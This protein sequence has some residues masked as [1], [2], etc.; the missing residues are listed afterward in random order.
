MTEVRHVAVIDVGKT[1]AK[2]ALVDLRTRREVDVRETPNVVLDSAPYPHHD[3]EGLWAFLLESLREVAGAHGVD[4]VTATTHG[5]A[6]VLVDAAGVP[7]VPMLDYEHDGPDELAEAYD[8]LRPD[9]A[10]SGSPRLP[11]GFNLGAQLHWLLETRPRLRDHLA[12]IVTYPQYWVGRLTGAWHTEVT[13]LGCHTDLWLPREGRLSGLADRLGLAG[14]M[15]PVRK[16]GDLVG[17]LLPA[18]AQQ[19]GL[20]RST[21]VYCGI[22]DS[23]ASLYPHLLGRRGPFSVL[24]TG[25]WVITMAIGGTSRELDPTRD[26]LMN[27]NAYGDPVPS[28]R[29]MGGREFEMLTRGAVVVPSEADIAAVLSR[30][31]TLSP[32]VVSTCGPFQG[33]AAAWSEAEGALSDGERAVVASFYLAMMALTCQELTGAEGPI[34]TEGPFAR[35]TPFLDLLAAAS[36]RQVLAATSSATGTSIGAALLAASETRTAAD[37]ATHPSP[38]S[39]YRE[40][41]VRYARR[42]RELAGI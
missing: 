29:F 35:N 11:H 5:A 34:I 23:N 21:P 13:S 22:H 4:A 9:F 10:R 17:T 27:V 20:P 6:A 33:R 40:D 1:N 32:A 38:P 24:S 8:A 16:A 25:T 28:A 26:T 3:I 12:Y 19:T 2:L 36:G 39:A 37:H 18:A 30:G 15:A 42:W 41:L 14:Q 7:V 31:V